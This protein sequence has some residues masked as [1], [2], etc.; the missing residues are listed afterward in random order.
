MTQTPPPRRILRRVGAV[1]AGILVT[2]IPAIGTDAVFHAV[3]L[4]PPLGQPMGDANWLFLLATGYRTVYGIAG[5]YLTA[6][7]APDRPML[8]SLVL[9]LVSFL[10]SI[11]G[12]AAT[13]NAE[14]SLGPKW[15]PL[16]LI[17]LALPTVWA[18][19]KIRELQIGTPASPGR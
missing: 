16:A 7:L 2:V 1:L 19:G 12:A 15:Y 5:S 6:R 18:G 3:G 14:P 10:V 13:W 8:H 9:G 4:F 11:I 17:V